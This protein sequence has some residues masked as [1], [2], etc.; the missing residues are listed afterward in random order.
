MGG[1]AGLLSGLF[2]V[3]GGIL[4]V[5]GLA[6]LLGMDQHRAHGTSLAA[7]LP[8]ALSGV[9]GYAMEG[10]VDWPAAGLLS[11][12]AVAGAVIG[13]GLLPRIPRRAL[14]RGFAGFLV[15]SAAA[16]LVRAPEALGRGPLDPSAVAGLIGLGLLSGSVAGLLG[17]GGGVI[18]IPALVVLFSV[19]AAVAKGT[20]LV[21]IIPTATA[22]TVQN[23]RRGNADLPVAAVTGLAGVASAFAASLLSVRLDPTLSGALFAAL[24]LAVALQLAATP[25]RSWPEAWTRR[26]T[27]PG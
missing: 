12:G 14:R 4:I 16:L 19:P 6:L 24:L 20:S 2:G 8:I 1:A 17:V 25:T 23:V 9:A 5:P 3:G 27:P 21:V 11:I 22:G 15:L 18:M 26:R 7:I 13:T 10:A